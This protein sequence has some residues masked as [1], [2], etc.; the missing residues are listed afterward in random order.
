V[1]AQ[2]H[3]VMADDF[4]NAIQQAQVK[5]TLYMAMRFLFEGREDEFF[6]DLTTKVL[7]GEL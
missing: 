6:C 5:T 4:G 1:E 7:Y 3:Q 2:A